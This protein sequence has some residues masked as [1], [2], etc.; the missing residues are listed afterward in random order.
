MLD[1]Y[2]I[3]HCAPTLASLKTASLFTCLHICDEKLQEH[4]CTWN[5]DLQ[6]K[7]LAL[8]TLCR[9]KDTALLYVYR[10]SQLQKDLRKPGVA[11]FL[12]CYGYH[13]LDTDKALE[14]LQIRLCEN[15]GFPHEIGLFLGY[16]LGDVIGFIE[17]GG[18]N[19]QYS[20]CWKVYGNRRE[21][22][23]RFDKYKK[24]KE[25]YAKLWK[26]GRSVLQLTV[27]A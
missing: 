24:C 1:K 5:A 21:A 11:Q 3:E 6:G 25:V 9:K 14:R 22:I 7:G 16:P 23:K 20:G 18:Q 17:N 4:V 2:L 27:A 8:V 19:F 15:R 12:S 10:K 13:R 26:Q